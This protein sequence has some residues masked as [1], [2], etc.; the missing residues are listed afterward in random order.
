MKIDIRS[1]V[2]VVMIVLAA[3]SRLLPHMPNFSPLEAIGLFGA[4]HF[5]KKWQVLAIPLAATW[6]SDLYL[7]NVVYAIYYPGFTLIYD[8]F[9]WQYG[10]YILIAV[11][12]LILLKR[13]TVG[14]VLTGALGASVIFF[15]ISNFGVWLGSKVYSQD[16]TGLI[17]C[18]A[19]GLPFMK[20]T[21]LGNLTYSALL[22]GSFAFLTSRFK[23][24]RLDRT[25]STTS[26]QV[27]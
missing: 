12:G 2:L 17:A 16:L 23:I 18:Y 3:F 8:G 13:V 10:P 15:L 22:F 20:G 25:V 14:R 11:L 27:Q 26:L 1:S 7:N 9:Y 5:T 21:L 19:A 6:L 24:L 4:A